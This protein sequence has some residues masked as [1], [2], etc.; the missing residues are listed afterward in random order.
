MDIRWKQRFSNFIKAYQELGEA[1]CLAN[2]RALTKLEQQGVI[3]G[4]EYTHELSWNVLK[5]Y[6]EEYGH[7]GL[8]GSKDTTREAF[9]RGLLENGE[10]WMEMIKSRNLTSHAYNQGL[11]EAILTD[12][13]KKYY[14][15][16]EEFAKNFTKFYNEE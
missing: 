7:T 13:L 12:I 14:P 3:Q 9:K 4:F 5:D 15:Q 16:F 10:I 1:A 11:A 6:L 2:S 8:I